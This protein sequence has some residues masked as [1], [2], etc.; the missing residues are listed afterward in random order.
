MVLGDKTYSGK[1]TKFYNNN[2]C[3]TVLFSNQALSDK[4]FVL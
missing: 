2:N 3:P 4:A 1:V